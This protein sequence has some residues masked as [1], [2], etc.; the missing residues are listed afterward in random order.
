M[1]LKSKSKRFFFIDFYRLISE[2]DTHRLLISITID[3]Y[4][5][6]VYRLTT[7]GQMKILHFDRHDHSYKTAFG[8]LRKMTRKVIRQLQQ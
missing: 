7:S 3:Y 6:S 2:I 4:R 8:Q 5:L 1:F